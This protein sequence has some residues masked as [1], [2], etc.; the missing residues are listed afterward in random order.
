MK[1]ALGIVPGLAV[2]L[3]GSRPDCQTYVRN[4]KKAC[5]AAGITS[6]EVHLP[7]DSSEAE[8]LPAVS[9]FNVDPTV[10]GILIQL[11]LPKVSFSAPNLFI[12][13]SIQAKIQIPKYRS[14][15]D[16]DSIFRAKSPIS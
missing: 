8:V 4:K 2:I 16:V 1:D 7:E 11:P 9:R 15:C 3:V 5:E 12:E 14:L 6:Q 13:C 10:H